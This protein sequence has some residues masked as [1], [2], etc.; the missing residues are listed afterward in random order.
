MPFIPRTSYAADVDVIIIGAGAAGL[1]AARKLTDT[2]FSFILL[3]AR[4][5][6]G[7]R[8]FTDTSTFGVP[9]DQ[10]CWLQHNAHSNPWVKFA[11]KHGFDIAPMPL[12]GNRIWIGKAEATS[13]EYQ[14]IRETYGKIRAAIAHAGGSGQDISARQAIEGIERNKW[15]AMVERWFGWGREFDEFSTRDWWSSG[16]GRPNYHC[17][18]GYGTLV[19]R[20][21]QD[22]PVALGTPVSTIDWSGPGV[23]VEAANRT[24]KARYC[25]VTVS[26]GVLAAQSIRFK[27]SLPQWKLDAIEA[28][29]MAKTMNVV[30]QFEQSQPLPAEENNWFSYWTDDGRAIS[31]VSNVG[32]WG[33]Q[34][35]GV[36]GRL[37]TELAA[38]GPQAT[39]DFAI[40]GLK[41]ALGSRI[42]QTFKKGW[43]S[44]W[45]VD[46][47]ARGTWS[48]AMPGQSYQRDAFRRP[49]GEKVYF[50]GEA[51]DPYMFTTCH[52]AYMSGE[53]VASQLAN[54]L[55]QIG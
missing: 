26:S 55:N 41:S 12:G 25:I 49:I 2:G 32:G 44:S 22:I 48:T 27:P 23:R 43:V 34:R 51:C 21:G 37:A 20:F 38:A 16:G 33:L 39:I 28:I 47:F 31:F 8:A 54:K 30:L 7:G 53:R 15:S 5:R 18:A 52:G 35:G 6:I 24:L 40:E 10:G 14:S 1:S 11:M 4:D 19:K 9:F 3:E 50:A 17:R 42:T 45:V 13:S 29:P 46:P 36:R